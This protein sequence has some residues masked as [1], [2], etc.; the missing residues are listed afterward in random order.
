LLAL[1][2][3]GFGA[4]EL[5]AQRRH[6][7][8]VREHAERRLGLTQHLAQQDGALA[9]E[10]A[11]EPR[12]G[13]DRLELRERI[14]GRFVPASCEQC[15][16]APERGAEQAGLRGE[17]SVVRI[18]RSDWIACALVDA[19]GF[20]EQ[21]LLEIPGGG[22]ERSAEERAG[23]LGGLAGLE[24]EPGAQQ[25]G[26]EAAGGGRAAVVAGRLVE[27]AAQAAEDRAVG[28]ALDRSELGG[29]GVRERALC[30]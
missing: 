2:L 28:L 27:R 19:A 15:A 9:R 22:A 21:Q 11:R 23:S 6:A 3:R 29:R 13:R 18:E 8:R 20:E 1:V 7:G 14:D 26:R 30:G 16:L 24:L 4:A 25:V 10:L 5:L 12:V 17:R